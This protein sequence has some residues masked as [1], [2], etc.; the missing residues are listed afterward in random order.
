MNFL[1]GVKAPLCFLI[2]HFFW[3]F[4]AQLLVIGVFAASDTYQ[5]F[6]LSDRMICLDRPFAF[7]TTSVF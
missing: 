2:L 7:N 4:F 6:P 1:T 3:S 5:M